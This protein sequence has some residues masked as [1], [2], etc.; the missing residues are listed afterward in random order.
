MDIRDRRAFKEEAAEILSHYPA[1][2]KLVLIWAGI[3]AV[4]SVVASIVSLLLD[5]Q[6][7]GTGGLSGIGLRSA[8]STLQS[9]LFLGITVV[10]PFW[11]FGYQ[12]AVLKMARKEPAPPATLLHGFRLFVPV[13]LLVISQSLIFAGLTMACIYGGTL[14]LSFTPLANPFNQFILENESAFLTGAVSEELVMAMVES[15]L[16]VLAGCAV[17]AL[18][19]IIPVFYKLRFANFCLMDAPQYGAITALR[20]SGLLMKKNRISLFKLDLSFWWF[21]LA[22]I[23]LMGITNV[24]SILPVLGINM[25][26]DLSASFGFYLGAMILEL[27]LFYACHNHVQVSYAVFYNSL[28]DQLAESRQPTSHVDI[29]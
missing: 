27:A 16:P 8:L 20:V 17:F 25:S 18:V 3:S 21:Y 10:L 29:P 19:V 1:Q 9:A 5:S 2:K 13:L 6:I 7:E 26:F 23:L 15:M 14:V 12:A 28:R 22:Q 11:N 4:L 24:E